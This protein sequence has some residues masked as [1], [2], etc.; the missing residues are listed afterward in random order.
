MIRR[1]ARVF[2]SALTVLSF[3]LCATTLAL[4]VRSYYRLD[5]WHAA[6]PESPGGWQWGV[7]SGKGG[8]SVH[9]MFF[10][11]RTYGASWRTLTA[12]PAGWSHDAATA[13]GPRHPS[14]GEA[15]VRAYFELWG[16]GWF[17]SDGG[18]WSPPPAPPTAVATTGPSSTS[19][20]L[21]G[22]GLL[23]IT[24]PTWSVVA[25][26]WLLA[27]VFAILPAGRAI[28][29]RRRRNRRAPGHCRHCGYDLRATPERC[30]ECGREPPR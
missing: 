15:G 12:A 19:L 26:H 11:D 14:A 10:D 21:T 8:V 4:W 18:T 5:A 30:P 22:G 25:P 27:G 29:W 7:R 6:M 2:I 1:T 20:T 23:F 13:V 3:L 9:A 24:F 28:A 16:L 17:R